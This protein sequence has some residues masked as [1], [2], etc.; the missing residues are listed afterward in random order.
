MD[1][2]QLFV[3]F[4]LFWI[5]L[6]WLALI[7]SLAGVFYGEILFA[8]I[9]VA[10]MIF[11]RLIVFNRATL[12]TEK[13]VFAIIIVTLLAILVFSYYATPTIFSGRDQGSF[14][15]AAIRLVQ[16]HHFTF[17]SLASVEFFKIYGP[18]KALNFPGFNYTQ[19]GL[20]LTQFPPG[21]ASWLA[22][23]Y[24]FFGLN[25]LIIANGAVLFVFFLTF[26]ALS[27][28]F[29]SSRAT[30]VAFLMA[31]TAFVFSWF[32]KFTLSENLA[33]MLVWF[34]IYAFV[35]FTEN[36]NRF[37]FV[38]SFLSFGL[39]LF[40][41]I[42]ALAFLGVITLVLLFKYR[43]WKYLIFVVLGKKAFLVILSVLLVY[44]FHASTNSEI[45]IA[46]IKSLFKPLASLKQDVLHT[47]G[48]TMLAYVLKI[49]ALYAFLGFLI[50]ALVGIAY[51]LKKRK[52]EILL[53]FLIV[54]PAFFY[55]IQPS[56]TP[57][58]P[59]MLRRFVFAVIPAL[60]FYTAWFLDRFLI[61]NILFYSCS[62]AL[63]MANLAVSVPYLSFSPDKNLLSQIEKLSD[64]FTPDD[65]ILIDREATGD[66]WSMMAGPIS[67]LYGKQ[68]VYFFNPSDLDK[69]DKS[70]FSKIYFVIPDD[71]L[72]F[73]E[74][75]DLLKR[76]A[77]QKDYGIRNN[78]LPAD[79]SFQLPQP[80][81][82]LVRGKIYILEKQ[83]EI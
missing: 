2:R 6:G 76:L 47:G 17:S 42:E 30:P 38:A 1:R 68:A 78:F 12:K 44:I 75:S 77:P 57:D 56:I 22:V 16:N 13:Q 55:L 69:I 41:R 21:Y 71:N 33:L 80:Q 64:N 11:L 54:L 28:Q 32:L 5:G 82:G 51:L 52:F 3:C 39:L 31:L 10:G 40:S 18:G 7:L 81:E 19:D 62:C 37:Y 36:K 67:F 23:F 49:F 53:P 4:G 60:I 72:K 8:Y 34:G 35:I 15:E 66:G 9:L 83:N 14:S 27:R 61:K 73:Y 50:F 65:L 48:L 20:L 29:L 63:I 70:K 24:Y 45:Y 79:T 43:D 26:Y 58:H 46:L 25:G 59:W 74:K